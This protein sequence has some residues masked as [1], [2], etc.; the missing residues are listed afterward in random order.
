MVARLLPQ[1]TIAE[2]KLGITA[3]SLILTPEEGGEQKELQSQSSQD[4]IPQKN[5]SGVWQQTFSSR[6]NV[7]LFLLKERQGE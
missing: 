1:P 7:G 3:L 4:Q 6:K 2:L 5:L